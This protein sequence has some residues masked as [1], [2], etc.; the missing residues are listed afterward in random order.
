MDS[1]STEMKPTAPASGSGSGGWLRPI[2]YLLVLV[3]FGA[4]GWRIYSNH[5]ASADQAASQAN[6]LQA[7]P[8]P[9]QAVPVES[10]PMPIYLNAL[11]T[12]TPYNSVTVKARVSGQLEKVN[13][14]EGQ[15]IHAGQTI[16]QIDPKP[17]KAALDQAKG[18]L[19]HDSALLKN[20]QA[21]YTRYKALFE[22]GIVSKEQLDLQQ[23][24]LGQYEGAIEADKAAIENTQLQLDWCT[25]Q[26]PITGKLGLR[27]VDAGNIITANTTNLVIVNQ[28]DPIAVYFTLP[29]NQLPQV[30]GMLHEGRSLTVEAWDRGETAKIATGELLTA[31]NQID[32]TTGTGKLKAVFANPQETLF[33]NQFVNIHLILEERPNA[34]VVPGAAIQTGTQGTFVWAV[35]P[36]NTV[37]N[38]SVKIALAEGQVTILDTGVTPGDKVVIDGADR[39]RNGA[40][41]IVSAPRAGRGGAAGAGAPASANPA[42]P[43]AGKAEGQAGAPGAA[44]SQHA[45][46]G[47]AG[48][49]PRKKQ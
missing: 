36:D 12:V 8:T 49:Q 5:K 32:T 38:Q 37:K 42:A 41:V 11:G 40:S 48:D 23:S 47:K 17:Y 21:E 3:L 1:I 20:A 46:P 24:N 26:S 28:V 30:L 25:V 44:T 19:A 13:F 16:L 39:L 14:T 7:R 2:L 4:A 33:P 43:W 45:W 9:V 22:A 31:D 34:L 29:E 10:R 6:A 35:Q 15:T 18:T 27:L